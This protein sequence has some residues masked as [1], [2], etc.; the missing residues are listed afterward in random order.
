[1]N[2]KSDLFII[3]LLV[4]VISVIIGLN[5]SKL[6]DNK[7]N[8]VAI[9]IPT[10]KVPNPTITLQVTKNDKDNFVVCSKNDQTR[11]QVKTNAKQLFP[12]LDAEHDKEHFTV[13]DAH[14]FHNYERIRND[15][16]KRYNNKDFKDQEEYLE[17]GSSDKMKNDSKD[18]CEIMKDE[19]GHS[20]TIY[21]G[22]PVIRVNENGGSYLTAYDFGFEARPHYTSCSNK[23]IAQKWKTGK[24]SL[25]PYQTSCNKPDKIAGKKYY[26]VHNKIQIAPMIDYHIRGHNYMN[27]INSITPYN[28]DKRILSQTTKGISPVE[29]R[30][31]NIPEGA[32]HVSKYSA[33]LPY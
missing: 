11:L 15:T 14:D 20:R 5:I 4:V 2:Y 33:H 10:I 19:I 29:R 16:I 3:I 9:N 12:S 7:I 17:N 26:K 24:K 8:N 27:Y 28:I 25:I 22:K 32:N 6:I 18:R 1:M 13:A 30:R 23:S 31:I 21:P